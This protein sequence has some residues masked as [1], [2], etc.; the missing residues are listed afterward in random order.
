MFLQLPLDHSLFFNRKVLSLAYLLVGIGEILWDMLPAGNQMGGAPANFAYHASALGEE[1][2]IVSRVGKDQLGVEILNHLRDLGLSSDFITLDEAHPTGTV[3]V[4]LDHDGVPDFTIHEGVAWDYLVD[5]TELFQFA[6]QADAVCFGSLA[7]R[8]TTS[9][10]TIMKFILNTSSETLRIFDINLRQNYYSKDIIDSS[11]VIANVLKLNEHE[12]QTLSNMYAFEGDE[13][14]RLIELS[15]RF[16]LQV[17]ALTKGLHGSMLYS[18]NQFSDHTGYKVK[19]V[20][21]VGA[22]DAFTAAMTI[23]MLKGYELDH[24]NDLANRVAAFV[25]TQPGG[26]PRISRKITELF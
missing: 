8:S 4:E 21:T 15:K 14:L 22:G 12:L 26:T 6:K 13:R 19:V 9:R 5:E 10:N 18:Q 24:L 16:D 23:G 7:Q 1:G 25:C 11:L 2:L 17:V 20:D 3:T